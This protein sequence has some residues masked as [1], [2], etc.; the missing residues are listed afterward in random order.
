MRAS[1][2]LAALAV[3]AVL[4][5][6]LAYGS[7]A[8]AQEASGQPY[9]TPGS[10]KSLLTDSTDKERY[11][12]LAHEL[13]CLVCQNQTL[14]DSDASLAVDL[15]RQ[16]ESMIV[17]GRSDDEIK[18]YLV[19]RYGDF[20]LYKPPMQS[21]TWLLWIGPFAL[22]ALGIGVWFAMQRRRRNSGAPT[23]AASADL[24]NARSATEPGSAELERARRLLDGN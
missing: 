4:A 6:A 7:S 1:T 14:A 21:N 15:R 10:E 23:T 8:S 13:R 20:V 11:K 19:E 2:R 16:L 3:A 9:L 18:K 22:L 12:A 24:A 17:D 5:T